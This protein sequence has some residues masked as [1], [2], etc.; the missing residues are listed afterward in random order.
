MKKRQKKRREVD[1][2]SG[3]YL[4]WKGERERMQYG[5]YNIT[6]AAYKY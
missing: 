6:R 3:L 1:A 5:Y 2:G 4:K